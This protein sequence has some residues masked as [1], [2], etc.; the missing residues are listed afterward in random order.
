MVLEQVKL[1]EKMS[2][3]LKVLCQK[4]LRKEPSIYA[5]QY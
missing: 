3:N 1:E 4:E 5:I 2:K